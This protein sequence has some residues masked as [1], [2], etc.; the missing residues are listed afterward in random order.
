M[1]EKRCREQTEELAV[2]RFGIV[3]HFMMSSDGIIVM[4]RINVVNSSC[5]A[6][7]PVPIGPWHYFIINKGSRHVG[8]GLPYAFDKAI[9]MLLSRGGGENHAVVIG[10]IVH[11][12]GTK[13]FRIKVGIK[14]SGQ[15][16]SHK[17]ELLEGRDDGRSL[18]VA[19]R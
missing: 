2:V 6:N 12:C 10:A 3:N 4:D 1:G 7:I 9:L 13:K 5:M 8:Q 18:A 16:S 15:F 14:V 17:S 19:E 11:N